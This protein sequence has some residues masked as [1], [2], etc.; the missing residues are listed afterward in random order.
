MSESVNRCPT[1]E[2]A[3][4]VPH[5]ITAV[6][7]YQR[8]TTT[9]RIV[10]ISVVKMSIPF[11][12]PGVW[13]VVSSVTGPQRAQKIRYEPPVLDGHNENQI[14]CLFWKSRFLVYRT[15]TMRRTWYWDRNRHQGSHWWT[16]FSRS[17]NAAVFT[18]DT[19]TGTLPPVEVCLDLFKH[20]TF[21]DCQKE[22]FHFQDAASPLMD[23]Y[24][25]QVLSLE[26]TELGE[27]KRLQR[28]RF[29]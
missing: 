6:D 9:K 29:S 3:T 1:F 5:Y 25:M 24:T 27:R 2:L 8:T 23:V 26:S 22:T 11:C 19:C 18:L 28:E 13:W 4:S 17:C 21:I 15:S 7:S 10:H 16:K 20:S 12:K 14:A